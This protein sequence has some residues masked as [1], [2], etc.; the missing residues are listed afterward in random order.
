MNFEKTYLKKTD[1]TYSTVQEK[2]IL[3]KL[4]QTTNIHL[5]NCDSEIS[6]HIY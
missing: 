6:A 1:Y 5:I 3:N 2:M 4:Y